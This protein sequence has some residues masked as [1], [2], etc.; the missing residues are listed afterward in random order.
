MTSSSADQLQMNGAISSSE[1]VVNECSSWGLWSYA[2]NSK[3]ETPK[4][5]HSFTSNSELLIEQF[6]AESDSR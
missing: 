6:V 2:P 4:L 5:L 3:L 1:F